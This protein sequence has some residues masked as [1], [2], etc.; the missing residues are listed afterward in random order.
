[1]ESSVISVGATRCR[2]PTTHHFQTQSKSTSSS[3]ALDASDPSTNDHQRISLSDYGPWTQMQ[4]FGDTFMVPVWCIRTCTCTARVVWTQLALLLYIM[5]TWHTSSLFSVIVPQS[6]HWIPIDFYSGPPVLPLHCAEDTWQRG[7]CL[8]YYNKVV[9]ATCARSQ[10]SIDWLYH[11]RIICRFMQSG[12]CQ[13]SK[14]SA[15]CSHLQLL[16]LPTCC[17]SSHL[18]WRILFAGVNFH[19]PDI[20]FHMST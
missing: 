18:C 20:R 8:F 11:R 2:V 6:C 16:E 13:C 3:A 12:R 10:R 1:M 5:G 4:P 7:Y 14:S 15:C 17:Y 9:P 19:S